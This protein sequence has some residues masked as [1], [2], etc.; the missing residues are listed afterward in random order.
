LFGQQKLSG[1]LS[2]EAGNPVSYATVCD[3]LGNG[4]ICDKW[5][6]F[7]LELAD[8]VPNYII[9]SAVGYCTDTLFIGE[10]N[11]AYHLNSKSYAINE[12]AVVRHHHINSKSS[13]SAFSAGKKEINELRPRN[14]SEVLQTKAGFTNKSGYQTPLTLR[15][16]SGKRL[17]V[18]R[19]GT[20]RFSSY[21]AGY[22]SHTINVY[23]LERI[24]VEKGAASVIY[25]AG[26]MAGIINLVDKSPF[27]QDGLNAKLTTGYGTVNNEKNLLACGGW[28][29]GKLAVKSGFRYRDADNFTYP[30][31]SVAENSFY[32]DKDLFVT[33]GYK[34]SDEQSI[35]FTA[36][37]HD[38]GPWG[39][40]VGFNASDYMR[41]QTNNERSD[42]YVLKYNFDTAGIFRNIEANIFYSNESRELMKNYYTAAGY[43]L[44]Y[45]ETTRFSDYYYGANVSSEVKISPNYFIKTGAEG[46]SFHIST[47]VDAVDYIG[48]F[49]FQNRV[50]E[51]ARNKNFGVYLE[52]NITLSPKTK[53]LAG[54]R[55]NY[56]VINE[57]NVYSSDQTEGQE[58]RKQALSGNVA[59]ISRIK[60]NSTLKIN[61]AHSFRMP[62]T[63]ELYTD[64]YTSNGILYGNP[65]LKPE[66]CNSFDLSYRFINNHIEF[67]VSPFLWLMDDMIS[68]EEIS[69]MAGTNYTYINIGKTRLFGG[70]VNCKLN[71][72]KVF[73]N[74]DNLSVQCGV[75]YLNGTDVTESADYWSGGVPLDYVPPFNLKGDISYSCIPYK[76]VECNFKIRTIWYTEQTRLGDDPYATPDYCVLGCNVGVR[77]PKLS[78]KPSLNVAVNNLANKEYYC[79]QSY[80]PSEGRDVRV[81]LT[82]Q[83]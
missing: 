59:V 64:N 13:V 53:A 29:N 48:A 41:V 63:T 6:R 56:A 10:D 43:I 40:P 62:E 35:V 82:F 71:F 4:V 39:K 51:D 42:N 49:S 19:N 76:N 23:D 1:T 50:S 58:Q 26:A 57:G 9:A 80:L 32:T 7:N 77:L 75:A 14:V 2:D 72:E 46:Y 33:T 45:T 8:D 36:D 52:N 12:V 60:N 68:K 61:V 70:E 65:D 31:G 25:G 74:D 3:G 83:F 66:Y 16:M 78:T 55:Y 21:P 24:E 20:R 67:E 15:G 73:R 18:L 28:S 44:S 38:G 79:Y 54:I 81:F 37:F 11:A 17:L 22:M 47:P 27:K 30:D 34:F 5:G 69:G